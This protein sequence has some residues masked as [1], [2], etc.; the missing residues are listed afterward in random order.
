MTAAKRLLVNGVDSC[1]GHG[2]RRHDAAPRD[3]R[4]SRGAGAPSGPLPAVEL[5]RGERGARQVPGGTV[6]TVPV[7]N[8]ISTCDT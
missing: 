3:A 4:A 5:V 8:P 6:I 7:N 1:L 2:T